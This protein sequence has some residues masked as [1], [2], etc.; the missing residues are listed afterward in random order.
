M[1]FIRGWILETLW[2]ICWMWNTQLWFF[3]EKEAWE[4][5][6]LLLSWLSVCARK[7]KR[8]VAWQATKLRRFQIEKFVILPQ[9]HP[10]FGFV[11][12]AKKRWFFRVHVR[13]L[14]RRLSR[15]SNTAIL[16]P[17]DL[18]D[19]TVCTQKMS[20]KF[21]QLK[22]TLTDDNFVSDLVCHP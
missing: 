22:E 8:S 1:I 18:G 19:Q 17:L 7:G 6:P 16:W 15:W 21:V 13:T 2:R 5:A 4:K 12:K 9:W 11:K 10:K 14:F 20:T 3:Q